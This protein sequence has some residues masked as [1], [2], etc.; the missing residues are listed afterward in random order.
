M[1]ALIGS[2]RSGEGFSIPEGLEVFY[3]LAQVII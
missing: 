3:D 2:V 1:I